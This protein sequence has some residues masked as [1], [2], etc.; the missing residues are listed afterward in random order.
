MTGFLRPSSLGNFDC[1]LRKEEAASASV[2]C[3]ESCTRNPPDELPADSDPDRGAEGAAAARVL[4]AG[5]PPDSFGCGSSES[6]PP[7]P[8]ATAGGEPTG[9]PLT[10]VPSGRMVTVRTFL[11]SFDPLAPDPTGACRDA[12]GAGATG[13]G[14]TT[15]GAAWVPRSLSATGSSCFDTIC[16]LSTFASRS[17]TILLDCG[18]PALAGTIFV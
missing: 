17:W 10:S 14:R 11:G 13:A 3:D 1:R 6:G 7:E 2:F 4:A 5:A 15:R 8:L 12:A 16:S 9:L 18:S